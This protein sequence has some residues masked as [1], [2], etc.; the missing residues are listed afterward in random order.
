ML[1]NHHE[2]EL[3]EYKQQANALK[4]KGNEAFQAGDVE[5]A[6]RFFSQALDIDPD[7]HIIYSNRSAAYMK[8][9][10]KSKA[11]YDAE[12]CVQLAP[13]WAKGYNRLGAAQQSLK[14]F[15]AAM[16]SFK[17]GI[18]LEPNNKTLWAALKGCQEAN[19]VDKQ[20]RFQAAQR[21]REVEEERRKRR[22]EIR[23]EMMKE[24]KEVEEETLLSS[25]FSEV[26]EPVSQPQ[27]NTSERASADQD[28]ILADFF[29]EVASAKPADK[30]TTAEDLKPE[31]DEEDDEEK[32]LTEKYVKQD[33][34]DGRSQCD[35]LMATHHEWKNLNP[36]YVLELDTDATIAD[37]KFRYKKLSLKVHPDRLRDI[38]HARQAF[39]YVKEAYNKLLD[40]DQRRTIIMHIENVTTDLKR[41]RKK[42]LAKGVSDNQCGIVR[43]TFQ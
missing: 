5:L 12:K 33:L 9:D 42:L 30:K 8:A 23:E 38:P 4:D 34:G 24:K 18:E 7:N 16:E 17:K 32:S 31:A 22:D 29:S 26:Q 37:I 11:L 28:D 6:I 36:F 43:S 13:N 1:D 15:D 35:R 19:E 2:E 20:Q 3:E 25:F 40:E 39:E 27:Q 14:R 10:S 21:E 41:E